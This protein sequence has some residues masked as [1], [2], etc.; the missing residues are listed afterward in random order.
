MKRIIDFFC[1]PIRTHKQK[2]ENDINNI[3]KEFANIIIL[4]N[5]KVDE[6]ILIKS[7]F[8]LLAFFL[9]NGNSLYFTFP[10]LLDSNNSNDKN[11][12]KIAKKILIDKII[13]N[14]N[15]EKTPFL[16]IFNLANYKKYSNVPKLT[17]KNQYE[18]TQQ[19]IMLTGCNRCDYY[20][21]PRYSEEY[22]YD[23]PHVNTKLWTFYLFKLINDYLSIQKNVKNEL[24]LLACSECDIKLLQLINENL[25]TNYENIIKIY[26]KYKSKENIENAKNFVILNYTESIKNNLGGNNAMDLLY[27]INNLETISTSLFDDDRIKIITHNYNAF[28]N[29][30]KHI[31]ESD[32]SEQKNTILETT[33][34]ESIH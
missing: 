4:M 21:Y 6:N 33:L 10:E 34:N 14:L 5:F 17:T 13:M 12:F 7:Y 23:Y 18:R 22:H 15:M 24:F 29:A 27:E 19:S 1:Y 11:N 8:H 20:S 3:A 26:K 25:K 32:K 28:V 16:N 31:Y 2:K 30:T 9:L